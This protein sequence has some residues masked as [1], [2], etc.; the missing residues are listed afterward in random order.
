MGGE[1]LEFV[2]AVDEYKRINNRPFPSWSEVFEII[3]YLGYRKMAAKGQHIDRPAPGDADAP[4]AE[5]PEADAPDDDQADQEDF[6]RD[7]APD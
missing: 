1:L 5:A 7:D 4:D 6:D 3:Q 2:L